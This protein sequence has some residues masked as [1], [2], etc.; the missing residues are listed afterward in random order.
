MVIEN[1]PAG[2]KQ[3]RHLLSRELRSSKENMKWKDFRP[4]FST[5]LPMLP[6]NVVPGTEDSLLLLTLDLCGKQAG[7]SVSSVNESHWMYSSFLYA[8][9]EWG[10]F[11]EKQK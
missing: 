11:I 10:F 2:H 4:C 3:R 1:F 8:Y 5:A 9:Q 7:L 6:H